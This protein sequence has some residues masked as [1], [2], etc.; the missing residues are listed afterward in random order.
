VKIKTYYDPPPIPTRQFDWCALDDDTY[1]GAPY[2]N[3]PIGL[4]ATEDEAIA[5]LKQQLE[6]ATP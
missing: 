2:S 5:D 6:E 3:C 1:D 4:G